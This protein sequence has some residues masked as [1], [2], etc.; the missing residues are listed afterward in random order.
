MYPRFDGKLIIIIIITNS[1]KNIQLIGIIIMII[2]III[3]LLLQLII[4][5]LIMIKII[6]N[7]SSEVFSV[8]FK[9][10][11]TPGIR[12]MPKWVYSF[13]PFR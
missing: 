9:S 10:F 1:I 13:R 3:M 6:K 11:Y 5:I 4:I 12:S 2:I 8:M 7:R